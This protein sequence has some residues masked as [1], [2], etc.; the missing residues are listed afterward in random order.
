MY[1]A[2]F[3]IFLAAA[4]C[5]TVAAAIERGQV[6]SKDALVAPL[7]PEPDHPLPRNV[8]KVDEDQLSS[9]SGA[10]DILVVHYRADAYV[11]IQLQR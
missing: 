10:T 2:L 7:S 4:N 6:V 5:P 8:I 3:L 9:A 11:Q 1:R